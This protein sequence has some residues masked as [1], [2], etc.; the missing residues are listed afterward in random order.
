[1]GYKNPLHGDDE[2]MP[3][4]IVSKQAGQPTTI[5]NLSDGPIEPMTLTVTN[6]PEGTPR[7]GLDDIAN[8]LRQA[9]AAERAASYAREN[10]EGSMSREEAAAVPDLT[11]GDSMMNTVAQIEDE[12]NAEDEGFQLRTFSSG[13]DEEAEYLSRNSP[14]SLTP[15]HT[16]AELDRSEPIPGPGAEPFGIESDL[17]ALAEQSGTPIG[18]LKATERAKRM[19]EKMDQATQ[20]LRGSME[21]MREAAARSEAATTPRP[22]VKGSYRRADTDAERVQ[23]NLDLLQLPGAQQVPASQKLTLD[24]E[25]TNRMLLAEWALTTLKE[26]A[27]GEQIHWDEAVNLADWVLLGHPA[28]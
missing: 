11:L 28:T 12:A 3:T 13:D 7:M 21:R 18:L 2:A 8:G 14:S 10:A 27:D 17:T 5:E 23:R 16:T 25:Q 9:K 1:M 15:I 26:A 20:S 19:Q 4:L 6:A 24:Q 22:Y